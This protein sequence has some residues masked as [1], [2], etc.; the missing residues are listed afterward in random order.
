MIY[1][2]DNIRPGLK[3]NGL[4]KNRYRTVSNIDI[5]PTL[6][7]LLDL[8][9]HKAVQEIWRNYTGYSLFGPVPDDR[10][11]IIMNNNEVARFKVGISLI[12][13]NYHYIYRMNIVPNRQEL[14]D[15]RKDPKEKKNLIDVVSKK[16]LK[17]LIDSFKEYE[18]SEKY[19]P[20]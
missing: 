1:L 20:K 12:K 8:K 14:Y 16:D 18:V 3:R 4:R 9:D 2:P 13:G 15:I 5:A 11:L 19:L 17:E 10:S 6:I 7:E